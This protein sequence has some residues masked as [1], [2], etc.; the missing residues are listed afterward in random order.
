MKNKLVPWKKGDEAL[1]FRREEHPFD[2]LHREID[3]L[4]DSYYRGFGSLGRRF[5]AAPG[6]E[7]SETEDEIRIK[8][9]LPGMDEKDIEVSLD[10]NVLTIHAERKDEHEEK[11][12]SYQVSEMSYGRFQRSVPLRTD[13]DRDKAKARFKRG[14]LTLTLPKTEQAKAERKQIPISVD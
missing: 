13:I 14:V 5:A 8:A 1:A 2:R 6:F 9:E 3:E 10:E 12:R 4:F 11:K 7:V